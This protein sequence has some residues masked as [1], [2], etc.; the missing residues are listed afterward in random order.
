L[1]VAVEQRNW[2]KIIEQVACVVI[3]AGIIGLACAREI[4]LNGTEVVILEAQEGIGMETSSR[5]S[6][7]IHAGIYYPAGTNKAKWCVQGKE[8]LYDY[9]AANH[10]PHNRLGKLIVATEDAELATLNDIKAKA[11]ANGVFDL[12]FLSAAAVHSLE[13]NVKAV[14]ALLSPSTGIIDSHSYMLSLLG[15]AEAKGAM[16]AVNSK[17]ISGRVTKDGIILQVKTGDSEMEL[18]TKCLINCAGLYASQVSRAIQGVPADQIPETYYR[19]GNYFTYA[20]KNPFTRL[21]YPVPVPGGLGTHSTVDLAG[22]VRFGPD[23]EWIE[24]INYDVDITRREQFV[25]AI[26]RYWPEVQ[27][28]LLQ[29]GYA[30]IRPTLADKQGGFRDFCVRLHDLGVAGPKMVGLYGIESPGL[31]SSLAIADW[32]HAQIS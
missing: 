31:T 21:I 2:S 7:V 3:G 18:Q 1:F 8:L 14:G 9:C 4:A 24:E 27:V 29:P 26:K 32:V 10:V 11:E 22:Q 5:H 16:L 25:G 19:K 17:L 30:G 23:V 12:E 13:P 28:E 15:Q 6:E 20:A